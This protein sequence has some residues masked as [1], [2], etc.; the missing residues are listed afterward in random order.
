MNLT[1]YRVTTDPTANFDR[2]V[3]AHVAVPID[4]N[5]TTE[6]A[7]GWCERG[8]ELNLN[9]VWNHSG[10]VAL[11]MRVETLKVPTKELKRLVRLSPQ[12]DKREAKEFLRGDLRRKIPSKIK[13][14]PMVWDLSRKLVYFGSQSTSDTEAFLSLFASTFAAVLELDTW[15]ADEGFL[16]WLFYAVVNEQATATLDDKIRLGLGAGKM[17]VESD[18]EQARRAVGE[19]YLVR[20]LP[21][22]LTVGDKT[23][24]V[25]LDCQQQYHSVK[26]P[27][28]LAENEE[29]VTEELALLEQLDGLVRSLWDR[30]Q[31]LRGPALTEQMKVW[32]MAEKKM[33][34]AEL[35]PGAAVN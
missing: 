21:I 2:G 8:D 10:H 34:L 35:A 3:R 24:G 19:G 12:T 29:E 18:F 20:E 28:I 6:K 30:Y 11:D 13:V 23:W 14:V 33:E 26:L 32:A 27:A 15:G 16:T 7:V 31:R 4:P 17:I 25:V 22:W 5:F 1:R 9:P